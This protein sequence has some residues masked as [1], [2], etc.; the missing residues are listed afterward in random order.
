MPTLIRPPSVGPVADSTVLVTP[1]FVRPPW[2]TERTRSYDGHLPHEDP[3]H[4][5]RHTII[6]PAPRKP[7]VAAPATNM[8]VPRLD[9]STPAPQVAAKYPAAGETADV[10]ESLRRA[11]LTSSSKFAGTSS[12]V[13]HP[14]MP[15][16]LALKS[17]GNVRSGF[18]FPAVATGPLTPVNE[19]GDSDWGSDDSSDF[20]E[21]EAY[22]EL[23]EIVTKPKAGVVPAGFSREPHKSHRRRK[24]SVPHLFGMDPAFSHHVGHVV[25]PSV[26][27]EPSLEVPRRSTTPFKQ[28]GVEG[29]ENTSG[30]LADL[31]S[32]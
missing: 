17:V 7:M 31:R 4:D 21:D 24:S 27:V 8:L 10:G 22:A 30:S 15:G 3:H 19:N 6:M 20:S 5:D 12:P 16:R 26:G 11:V 18:T 13:S 1:Q 25:G 9:A 23:M 32:M 29:A 28:K 14:V 2:F